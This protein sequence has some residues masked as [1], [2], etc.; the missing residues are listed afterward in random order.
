MTVRHN[1]VLIQKDTRIGHTTT[2]APQ[3]EDSPKPGPLHL[4]DHGNP[5]RYRNVWIVPR[6]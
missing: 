5:V 1:G 3:G 2:A 4:Q 6:D